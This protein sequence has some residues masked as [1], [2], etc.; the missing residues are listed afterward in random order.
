MEVERLNMRSN[1]RRG[2]VL[3]VVLSCLATLSL[4]GVT[5]LILASLDRTTA[6]NYRLTIQA[7]LIA[8]A[9]VE[10]A[11]SRLSGPQSL[12]TALIEGGDWK[13]Y[14]NDTTG[15]SP[16]ER[17]VSL[18]TAKRPSYA[19]LTDAGKVEEVRLRYDDKRILSVGL[20]GRVH[21]SEYFPQGSV[22]SL[23]VRDLS[24]CIYVNDG[25]KMQ[26]GN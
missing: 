7:R 6:D 14:G 18:S 5:F 8:R 20:S 26:G 19:L 9:G 23:E 2:L 15:L 3:I 22:Y 17:N 16:L 1:R 12:S 24:G 25:L 21:G 4:C 13:Y 10:Y 11:M